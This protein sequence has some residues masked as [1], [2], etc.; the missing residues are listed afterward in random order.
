MSIFL[1]DVE[2]KS[3]RE[4]YCELN[5]ELSLM[6]KDETPERKFKSELKDIF[7]ERI[8]QRIVKIHELQS[9]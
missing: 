7:F 1:Y 6:P 8:Y 3:Y 9:K 2:L 5:H 4:T